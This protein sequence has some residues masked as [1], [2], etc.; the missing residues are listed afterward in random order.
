MNNYKK[1]K[2]IIDI[3]K[4]NS[5][6]I[7][8]IVGYTPITFVIK[9]E[10]LLPYLTNTSNF[11]IIPLYFNLLFQV[12]LKMFIHGKLHLT[13]NGFML[14]EV[15][16]LLQKSLRRPLTGRTL[17]LQACQELIGYEK[18]QLPWYSI[19]TYLF[20]DHC[21]AG[22]KTLSKIYQ[23]YKHGTK[24][25]A[26]ELLLQ[27]GTCRIA[28]CL[29]VIATSS[30]YEPI[31][32]DP[33]VCVPDYLNGLV[34][35]KHQ[36]VQ[37][38]KLLVHIQLAWKEAHQLSLT[39]GCKPSSHEA[40][41]LI[42]YI[43]MATI[44]HNHEFH[45][46]SEKGKMYLL[47]KTRSRPT[48]GLLILSVLY[49]S[50]R[51]SAT[52]L[53][54][55]LHHCFQLVSIPNVCV[56]LVLFS[57]VTQLMYANIVE[58]TL[59]ASEPVCWPIIPQLNTMPQWAV[60]KH[61]FRG[62]YGKASH[63]L[64]KTVP[65]W[66]TSNMLQ[67]FHGPR[68]K[69]SLW[70]F[71]EVGSVI[72]NPSL[73]DNPYWGLTK[74]IYYAHPTREQKTNAITKNYISRLKIQYP[75]LFENKGVVCHAESEKMPLLSSKSRKNIPTISRQRSS[76][77][78][79][80]KV[81][82]INT[83]NEKSNKRKAIPVNHDIDYGKRSRTSTSYK[84]GCRW[85][86]SFFSAD[87]GEGQKSYPTVWR[88]KLSKSESSKGEIMITPCNKPKWS[89]LGP[90]LQKPTGPG[91]V[92]TVML[93][94]KKIV[95]K[96]PYP[97][98]RRNL[99]LF[100]HR[101]LRG[102]LKDVHVLTIVDKAPYLSF[103][104]L[105]GPNASLN[106]TK[107]PYY[108]LILKREVACGEFVT[109]DSLGLVQLHKLNAK[110]IQA[111]PPSLWVH[112][113]YRFALNIGD[114]GL[115][116]VITDKHAFV[117]GIDM[118]ELRGKVV[119]HTLLDYMFVKLPAKT[120]CESIL[121]SLRSKKKHILDLIERQIDVKK[122]EELAKGYGVEFSPVQFTERIQRLQYILTRL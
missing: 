24:Y 32:F 71:F 1:S 29:G 26:I 65:D 41:T 94:Q 46:I 77:E 93:K 45:Y 60:D 10:L 119:K 7:E 117:Y 103:P 17:A 111:L 8:F 19:I 47:E 100:F 115:Y 6:M 36:T 61:T 90:L 91:K 38:S 97:L 16:S 83:S 107:K 69:M 23:F 35:S 30:K 52:E 82:Q 3:L 118:E 76:P 54:K 99:C 43:E 70:N 22:N 55:Y 42:S 63:H 120:V 75:S 27:C 13:A 106:I 67:I 33:T 85:V 113:M 108:D 58:D 87:N 5:K 74:T 51:S 50:T 20:E 96:G 116:N 4:L 86:S 15:R 62:K 80:I 56:R 44:A 84:S 73:N 53:R 114:T 49:K 59:L 112:F 66:M 21:L 78:M 64:L 11:F 2:R 105:I 121:S 28:A 95:L 14:D 101:A 81:V 79:K 9:R 18:D 110:E 104:L 122:I 89:L 12:E 25:D 109:R 37:V 68:P 40:R 48:V 31:M 39:L 72:E 57:A 34:I 102:I 88:K 92:H 98:K